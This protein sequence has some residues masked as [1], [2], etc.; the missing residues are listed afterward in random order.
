ME[1]SRRNPGRVIN[2]SSGNGLSDHLTYELFQW[3]T[4]TKRVPW[5]YRGGAA[6]I[7]DVKA[8]IPSRW[9]QRNS[10]IT[11]DE[12]PCSGDEIDEGSRVL[13]HP[14]ALTHPYCGHCT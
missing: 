13:D 10:G 11:V 3:M 1:W 9:R 5:P 7:A 12:K 8:S 6:A 4:G 2:S 14:L